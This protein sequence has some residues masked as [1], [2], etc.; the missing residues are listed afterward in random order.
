MALSRRLELHEVLCTILGSRNVYY[1][2][3]SN[4]QM[5]YPC[6]IYHTKT[7]GSKYADNFAYNQRI[8]YTVTV[9]DRDPDSETPDKVGALELCSFDRHYVFDNM[10]H[11]VYSLYF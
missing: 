6:I 3:P 1:Q 7:I 11:S 4:V 8:A 10:N 9:V 5:K 2:P